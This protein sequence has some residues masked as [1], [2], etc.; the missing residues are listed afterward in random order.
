[1]NIEMVSFPT[2][3]NPDYQI[4]KTDH[5][6]EITN[7]TKSDLLIFPGFTL[8]SDKELKKFIK[9]VK[10]TKTLIYLEVGDGSPRPSNRYFLLFQNG[11]VI[12]SNLF[13]MFSQSNEVDTDSTLMN[14]YVKVLETERMF[15][16]NGKVLTLVI[17]GEIN[18]LKNVQSEG[19][20]VEIRT[21]NSVILK[22]YENI[23]SNTDIFIN[24]QHTPMGNQGKLKKRREF[25]S[26]NGK[27]YCSTTNTEEN[28]PFE[29]IPNKLNGISIQY[30][31]QNGKPI[32]EEIESWDFSY[33]LK[34]Y[35]V[36]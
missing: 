34:R 6:I 23:I 20:R 30:C 5:V 14:D 35:R 12:H 19:N 17:C 1:M 36:K 16:F 25:L 32:E 24:P 3:W 22:K 15:T 7:T 10:N 31:F 33:I 28:I 26:K 21:S 27:V 8:Y 2:S 9:K 11:K 4:G 18:F 13:Q 29:T